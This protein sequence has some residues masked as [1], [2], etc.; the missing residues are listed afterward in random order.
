MEPEVSS[1]C[2]QEPAIGPYSQPDE[3]SPHPN[4]QYHQDKF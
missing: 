3:S 2:S 4:A 1:P